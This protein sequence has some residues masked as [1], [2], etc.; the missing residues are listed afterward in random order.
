[1]SSSKPF[2][3]LPYSSLGKQTRDLFK[4]KYDFDHG[5]RTISHSSSSKLT[6]ESGSVLSDSAN[7]RGYI[8]ASYPSFQYGGLEA[9]LHTDSTKESF[10]KFNFLNLPRGVALNTKISSKDSDKSFKGPVEQAQFEYR[11]EYIAVNATAK[12]DSEVHKAEASVTVG[13]EGI[14]VGG[15]AT[16]DLSGGADVTE[17]NL[18]LE[19]EQPD[20]TFTFYTENNGLKGNVSYFQR[21]SPNHVLGATLITDRSSSPNVSITAAPRSF[22]VGNEYKVAADTVIKTKIEIPTGIVSNH[23]EHR[24]INPRMLLGIASSWN[25]KSQKLAAEKVGVNLTFGDF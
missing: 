15:I 10:A 2:Y 3:P 5:L 1:M 16:V 19:W 14:S 12:T 20:Y 6:L 13:Y 4:K 7:L 23:I 8:K 9:E 11:Q 17:A 21:L 22:T 25:I 24:L 18:A